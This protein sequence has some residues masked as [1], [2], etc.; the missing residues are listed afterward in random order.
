MW[1]EIL[2]RATSCPPVRV[3]LT[4]VTIY[5]AELL[6]SVWTVAYN[7]VPG[8]EYTR[9]HTDYLLAFVACT[10]G[11]ALLTGEYFKVTR[12]QYVNGRER[13]PSASSVLNCVANVPHVL[14]NCFGVF[15]NLSAQ[16]LF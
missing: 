2:D 16:E 9:E 8:G 14:E 7:F 15:S 4:A 12:L 5:V 6:F 3:V 13:I 11:L 10:I 1:P